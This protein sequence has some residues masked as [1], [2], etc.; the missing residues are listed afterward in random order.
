[1]AAVQQLYLGELMRFDVF[2][3]Q[4]FP[5]SQFLDRC[6]RAEALGFDTIW[7]ADH[8]T[9][10]PLVAYEAFSALTAAATVTSRVR[11]GVLVASVTL[12]HPTLLAKAA[13]TVD[14]ASSGRLELGIGAGGAPKDYAALGIAAWP[15]R[16]RV[17]RLEE[18]VTLIDALF[19]GEPVNWHGRHYAAEDIALIPP[20]QRP[21]PPLIVA[22]Q[23][24]RAL[25]VVARHADGWNSL[26]GH[27][28][29]GDTLSLNAAVRV[30]RM[31]MRTLEEACTTAGRDPRSLRRSVFGYK[32][33][34]RASLDGFHEFVS[35]YAE[36]G[37]DEFVVIWPRQSQATDDIEKREEILQRIATEEIPKLRVRS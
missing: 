6:R 21:R 23:G 16:E 4:S 1:M 14:H 26:G 17:E 33:D 18:S 36:V 11:L 12:R 10:G 32:I 29:S 25:G 34:A 31:Q 3:F 22:A 24:A 19:R 37:F 15:P 2:V 5:F 8:L 7:L 35:R 28:A 20:V 27:A 30:A 9:F 13:L